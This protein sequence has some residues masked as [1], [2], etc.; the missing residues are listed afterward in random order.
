M[1]STALT[2]YGHIDFAPPQQFNDV[3][4]VCWDQNMT[5]MGGRKWTQLTV[6][7]ESVF[8]ANGGRLDYVKLGLQNDVAVGGVRLA[9]SAWMLEMLRGSTITYVGQTET[10]VNFGGFTTTDK[11]RRFK[12]CATDMGNGTVKLELERQSSTETRIANGSFPNGPA[13]V[14]FQDVTYDNFKGNFEAGV[15]PMNTNT[16]H[17]DNVQVFTAS[18]SPPPSTTTTVAPTTTISTTTVVTTIPTTTT[19]PSTTTTQAPTTTAPTTTTTAPTTTTTAPTTTTTVP[20]C[21]PTFNAVELAWC[22]LVNGRLDAL[23]AG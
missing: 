18:A 22:Q 20:A 3:E 10:Y 17:W 16:W 5:E 8:Q 12:Q 11:A 14:I 23:E 2:G 9:G 21:P 19:Q 6:V 13:R 4:K 15:T 7:P 1:T